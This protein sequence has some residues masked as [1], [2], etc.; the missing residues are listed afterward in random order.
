MIADNW[1]Q[2]Y[3]RDYMKLHE[4]LHI[5]I[6]CPSFEW[7]CGVSFPKARDLYFNFLLEVNSSINVINSIWTSITNRQKMRYRQEIICITCI[8]TTKHTWLGYIENPEIWP[9]GSRFCVLF[10]CLTIN[11]PTSFLVTLRALGQSHTSHGCSCANEAPH[12]F[13]SQEIGNIY[14]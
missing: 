5:Y 8:I 6:Y 14:Q 1:W 11:F 10:N 9:R 2:V 4:W 3:K 13:F 12:S 7:R